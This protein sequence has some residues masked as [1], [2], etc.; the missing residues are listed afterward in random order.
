MAVFDGGLKTIVGDLGK[1]VEVSSEKARSLLGWTPMPVEDS[2]DDT[3]EALI[4]HGS[5]PEPVVGSSQR[6]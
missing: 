1:R 4:A 2:I 6:V 5:V 3:A